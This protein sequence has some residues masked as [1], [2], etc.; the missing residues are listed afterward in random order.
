MKTSILTTTTTIALLALAVAPV[1]AGTLA[2]DSNVTGNLTVEGNS[3]DSAVLTLGGVSG[4]P[5]FA[6]GIFDDQGTATH[7][8]VLG[9]GTYGGYAAWFRDD[10]YN[11]DNMLMSLNWGTYGNVTLN[12]QGDFTAQGI[13]AD[14]LT[15]EGQ[16]VLSQTALDQRYDSRYLRPNSTVLV[17]GSGSSAS[18]NSAVALGLNA[19]S[20]G[21]GSTA[22]GSGSL[23]T[24]EGTTAIGLRAIVRS[25]GGVALGEDAY[26]GWT[27]EGAVGLGLRSEA[28]GVGSVAAGADN[29]ATGF[30]STAI[31]WATRASGITSVAIGNQ[32]VA[33]GGAST[34]MGALTLAHGSYST[35]MGYQTK[36]MK[37]GA[38]AVGTGTEAG[39]DGSFAAGGSTLASGNYSMAMGVR[40]KATAVGSLA[41]GWETE[42]NSANA[43]AMG[44]GTRANG[45][46]Q[47]VVGSYNV[48]LTD[49]NGVTRSDSDALLIVGNGYEVTAGDPS[50]SIRRNA[51]VVRWN[52]NTETSGSVTAAGTV[53]STAV[54]GYN[55]FKAP[56]LV[57]ASGDI[58]MGEFTAGPQP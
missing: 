45:L 1:F 16:P 34:A 43:T 22:I 49:A 42:A 55:K 25:K 10:N 29:I 57:A 13:T 30:A 52:G 8:T 23:A 17:Y 20:E 24:A 38:T 28:K 26:V 15:L 47:F 19:H 31:G 53:Q 14:S 37:W 48:P 2:G 7:T 9:S 5:T 41:V 33:D 11:W 54:T 6:L 46:S 4:V 3:N 44:I 56:V 32:T 51:F 35:A 58:S 27:A 39:G 40:S 18:G 50:T 12:L 21:S 36:A